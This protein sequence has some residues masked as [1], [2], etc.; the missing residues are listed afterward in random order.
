MYEDDENSAR[1]ALAN[2]DFILTERVVGGASEWAETW[3]LKSDPDVIVRLTRYRDDIDLSLKSEVAGIDAL[4]DVW[5]H[6][7]NGAPVNKRDR[8]AQTQLRILSEFLPAILKLSRGSDARAKVQ[9]AEIYVT[10]L[11][12]PGWQP[13]DDL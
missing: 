7:V 10:K 9:G 1:T 11:F 4:P 6:A 2:L 3:R 12:F 8:T 13:V 5:L